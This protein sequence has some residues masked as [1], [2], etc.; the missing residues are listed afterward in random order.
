M[1]Q[2]FSVCIANDSFP[3]SNQYASI[4]P[5]PEFALHSVRPN[6]LC[7]IESQLLGRFTEIVNILKTG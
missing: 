2:Q 5:E 3:F 7:G 4:L 6:A 1:S